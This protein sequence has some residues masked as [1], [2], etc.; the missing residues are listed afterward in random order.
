MIVDI[1]PSTSA[2]SAA[3][4]SE[5]DFCQAVQDAA[6]SQD[7]PEVTR[8]GR[9]SRNYRLPKRFRDILPEPA[10][11][12]PYLSEEA[13]GP[14]Q[15]GRVKRVT[16]IVRDHLISAANSFGIWRNY[17]DRPTYDPDMAL[18]LKDLAV[19]PPRISRTNSVTEEN[20]DTIYS[21]PWPFAN[22]TIQRVMQ[23]LNNGN[24]VKSESQMNEFVKT[25]IMSPDFS[26][27]HLAGFDAHRENQRLDHALSKSSTQNQFIET[28]VEILVPSGEKNTPPKKFPVQGLLYRKITAVVNDAFS[29]SLAHLHH[30]YPFKLY[31]HSPITNEE[32]RIFGEIYTSDAFQKE[33]EE[34]QRRGLLPPEDLGCTR[35]K[36]VAALM[37]SSDATHLT[38]F[39]NAKAWPIYLMLGNLSKYIRS[40]PNSGAMHHLAYIPSVRPLDKSSRILSDLF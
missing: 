36:V 34:I 13:T 24:T 14:S 38:D 28:T 12:P 18:S 4:T 7:M 3:T 2:F 37:F 22:T 29:G 21:T 11:V 17:T 23:W 9:P 8:T 6:P 5:E 35:E 27:E 1:N 19:R 25:V 40:K 30:F 39:G 32:E 31:H 20:H 26:Q 15:I 33:H 16:L 10:S